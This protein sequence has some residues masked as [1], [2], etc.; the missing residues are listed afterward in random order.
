MLRVLAPAKV[1][2]HLGVGPVGPDGYHELTSV[3]HTLDLADEIAVR[4]ADRLSVSCTADLG[5]PEERN[6]AYRAAVAMGEAFG[7]EPA[8][9]VAVDKRIP[10][11]GGLGGGSSDAAAV[12]AA[13]AVMRGVDPLDDRC[14]AVARTLGA[15][16]SFFL[17]PG[18][19]ALMTGRGDV[20]ERELPACAGVPV[21]LVA[22]RLP[23][24]TAAAYAA[25]DAHPVAADSPARVVAALEEGDSAAVGHALFNNLTSAAI[26]VVAEVGE[27]LAWV[28][29]C[30]GVT[31]AL[32]SGSGSTVF[33]LCESAGDVRRIAD[34]AS[35]EGW[36]SAATA[37]GARGVSVNEMGR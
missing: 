31:G 2:L 13:L 23:V 33:A 12:I 30:G 5:I 36:W 21:V 22:P 4:P 29:R 28:H 15:D 3:F 11:G 14:L 32:V 7:F 25:F 16:V 37:L 18:G 9:H 35:R 8:V 10:S 24:S 19:A 26:S 27:A 1:N 17:V 34:A 20:V 6:L